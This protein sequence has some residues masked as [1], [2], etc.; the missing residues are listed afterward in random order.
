MT[1]PM[2]VPQAEAQGSEFY[3]LLFS[4]L[5]LFASGVQIMKCF[6]LTEEYRDS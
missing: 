2:L 3:H 5:F 1:H 6:K 4:H